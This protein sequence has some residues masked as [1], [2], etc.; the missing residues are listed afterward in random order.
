MTPETITSIK[1]TLNVAFNGNVSAIDYIMELYKIAHIWDDIIDKDKPLAD[2][3]V[4]KAFI[5]TLVILPYNEFYRQNIDYLLP[6]QHNAILQWIDANALEK[7]DTNSKHKAYMLKASFLQI[8]NCCA[9]LIGGNDWA[10]EIG[11][12]LRNALYGETLEQF[13]GEV[14]YA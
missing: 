7:M 9:A 11:A 2:N 12:D 6:L 13:M 4:H 8:V 10:I 1:M 14:S 3:D 5:A